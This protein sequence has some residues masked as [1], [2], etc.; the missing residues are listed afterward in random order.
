MKAMLEQ[1]MKRM[2]D[3]VALGTKRYE[4]QR[5]VNAQIAQDLHACRKQID[6]T[7][8]DVDEARQAAS[9]VTSP[10]MVRSHAVDHRAAAAGGNPGLGMPGYP[11]LA[12][13]G[14]PLLPAAPDAPLS[15]PQP[16][17]QNADIAPQREREDEGGFV[18]PPKHDFPRFDGSLPTLWLDRCVAYFDMYRVKPQNWV[19][20]ASLYVDGHAALWL[21]AYRQLHA[22]VSW[23]RFCQAVVEEFGPDE[24][25][26]QMHK[27]LQLRQTGSV[28]EYRVQFEVYMYHLLALDPSLSSKF[29]VTKFV[30]GLKDEL[31]AT[32][33]IQAPT[34][35]TRATVFAKIQEEELAACR[36]R[37]RPAPGGRPPPAAAAAPQRPRA[38]PDDFAR[39]RQLRDFRRAN[40]LCFKCG[41]RYSRDHQCKQQ[42]A[43]LLTIQVGEFGEVLTEDVV[44]ALQL[45]DEPDVE[46]VQ[47]CL[48][49][50]QATSGTESPACIRLSARVRDQAM[51]LLLDSGSSHS[52]VSSIFVQRLSYLQSPLTQFL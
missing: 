30:L 41:D 25:E 12:N 27:L 10:T 44:H 22:Q 28:A 16:V 23:T 5:A 29:F 49:S 43:Q 21:Q 48:L 4:E 8:A 24:F 37:S 19:T 18:K 32:V 51:L 42:G 14:A 15:R 38:A 20:T 36:P 11:R 17:R 31:R 9:T 13:D 33:R 35:I 26:D 7:Q 40:N 1:I 2:D 39:E 6:L 52:F 3:N 50:A 46:P 47:C 34:S 45:L